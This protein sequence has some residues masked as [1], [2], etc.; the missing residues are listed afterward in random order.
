MY[1]K[2]TDTN[3]LGQKGFGKNFKICCH[4]FYKVSANQTDRLNPL[5]E[6][7]DFLRQQ[8]LGKIFSKQ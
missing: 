1:C 8:S 7:D 5:D 4:A 6:L 3:R 2:F